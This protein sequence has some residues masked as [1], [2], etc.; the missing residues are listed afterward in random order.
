MTI[1][2]KIKKVKTLNG[3]TPEGYIRDADTILKDLID[4]N[5]FEISGMADDIFNIYNCSSDKTAVKMM[6]YEFTGVEFEEYLD[7]CLT[8]IT[9][10]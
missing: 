1:K 4:E 2:Q 9:R 8:E 6:F 10:K 7:K 3:N 5:D